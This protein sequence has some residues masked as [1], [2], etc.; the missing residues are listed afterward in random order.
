MYLVDIPLIRKP[1]FINP[2][3]G[4]VTIDL[5]IDKKIGEIRKMNSKKAITLLV[6]ATLLLTLVPIMPAQA[7]AVTSVSADTGVYGD[8]LII[9]GSGV[10]AGKTVNVYWDSVDA[11]NGETGLLNST[12]AKSSGAF[13]IWID[14]PE[15]VFGNHY[16][17][18]QDTN[19]GD[20]IVYGSAISVT[21]LIKV[22][23]KSALANDE[24][25]LSGYGYADDQDIDITWAPVGDPFPLTAHSDDLGS[26]TKTFDLPN[27]AYG[28][29]EQIL[30]TDE[31]SNTNDATKA[32]VTLSA[33]IT[34]D[35]EIGP[36]GTVVRVTGRGFTDSGTIDSIDIVYGGGGSV[37]VDMK[38]PDD[39]GISAL[40]KFTTDIVIPSVDTL[41][42]VSDD[43]T[44][45]VSDGVRS[46]DAD[47]E[48]TGLPSIAA[49]PEYGVQGSTVAV[50]GYNWTQIAD[51]TVT[52]YLR[53]GSDYEVKDFKTDRNG[54]ISGTFKIPAIASDSYEL[55]ASM[56][57]WNLNT[58][59]TDLNGFKV[60]LMI[61]ILSPESGPTGTVVS[62]T[63]SGWDAGGS[64][65][66]NITGNGKLVE[67]A[68]GTADG[69]GSIA[70]EFTVPQ[71]PVG[72]YSVD[73]RDE[74]NKITVS[75]EFEVTGVPMVETSPM[76]APS[77]YNVTIEGQH[78]SQAAGESSLTFLLYNE[79]DEWDLTV[80]SNWGEGVDSG[81]ENAD[82]TTIGFNP[83]WDDG[84]WI[85]WFEVPNADNEYTNMFDLDL[86]SY[87]INITDG[88]DLYYQY[89]FDVVSKVEQ[90]Q[91][92]KDTFRIGET[93]S[94][95]VVS[96][97]GQDGS[98]IEIYTPDGDLYWKTE[99]FTADSW[100]TVGTEKVYPSFSQIADGNLMT[101]L[102]DAPLGT[103][104]WTWFDGTSSHDELDSGVFTVEASTADVLG[105]QVAD[106]NNKITDLQTSVASVSSE[107]DSVKS[108]I[109]D[110]AAVAQQAVT[111]ANQ[112]AQAVQ[113]VAQT[114]NQANTAA[115]NAADAANAAKDAANSLT[116]LVYGAIGAALVAALAA[117]VSLMQISRR[118]AG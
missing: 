58:D 21:P 108:Q 79:T 26:W 13:E 39:T 101:L 45:V 111:A 78:F 54:K 60:G 10:T 11:W 19:T 116:T 3:E 84:S 37:P 63:A 77:G 4:L 42:G 87:W 98:Y 110:V 47:F 85:G 114:A 61:V 75:A 57:D 118:I 104:T 74:D 80:L 27:L 36:T 66:Y 25:T 113:T 89:Q 71:L 44:I 115:Q 82:P 65:N 59:P 112:A 90:I 24:I 22:K 20:T 56:P 31:D 29:V 86:G 97:F 53:S 28:T 100:I 5:S 88:A 95:N 91:P 94:F 30:G 76:V 43:Y 55:Y 40:G 38:N 109:S 14:I 15:A 50:V 51:E 81:P 73:V 62:L 96:T 1:W 7:V 72:V 64:Y 70:D 8:T 23:P 52:L 105:T 106:L 68:S 12:K 9:M 17:W 33:A 16:L 117:I 93:V 103:W 6:L 32:T 34:L 18:L 83:E 41:G 69:S 2:I 107:F 35:K 49:D 99:P 102:E 48:V 46:G 92:R 67:V